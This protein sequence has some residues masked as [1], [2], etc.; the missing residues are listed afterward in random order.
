MLLRYHLHFT[1]SMYTPAAGKV[2]LPAFSCQLSLGIVSSDGSHLFLS[3]AVQTQWWVDAG[4]WRSGSLDLVQDTRK[5]CPSLQL[6]VG[7]AEVLWL[8]RN[9]LHW[10]CFCSS[11][12]T[13]VGPTSTLT[14]T[15]ITVSGSPSWRTQS[16]MFLVA[17]DLLF[18]SS[19]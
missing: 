6:P 11:P 8:H 1:K 5:H 3:G 12:N 13:G 16:V 4:L 17:L 19:P 2:C 7:W 18:L 14:K 10:F 9:F 15:P